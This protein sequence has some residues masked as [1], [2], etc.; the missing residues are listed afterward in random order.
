VSDAGGRAAVEATENTWIPLADGRR[1]AARLW[2]PADA[3]ARPAPAVVEY[4]PYRKRDATR[5]RDE[6]IHAWLAARGYA[7]LRVDMHGSGDSDGV[8]AQEFQAREQDDACEM[9]AWIAAQPWCSGA[10]AMLGKSWGA[11]AAI[12]AAMR[13]PPALKA[14]VAVC[15]AQDRYD[16]SLHFTGGVPLVEQLWWSDAMM[17][18]N[19]RPPDPDIAGPRW[20][21]MWRE[22]LEANGPWIVEWLRHQ[23]RDAFWRHGSHADAPGAIACPILAVGGW[24]DYISRAVPRMLASARAPRWGIV[25]PWGHHYP[26][27]GIPGPAIGFMEECERFLAHALRGDDAAMAGVP[28]LRAWMPEERGLGPDHGVERGRWVAEAA[29]PSPRIA[30][31]AFFPS[32]TGLADAPGPEAVLRHRSSQSIGECA[33]EWLSM[34]LPGEAPR[35]QRADDGRSLCLDTA[36]LGERIEILGAAELELEL[37][38]D[39]PVAMLVARLCDVAPDGASTRVALG[40]LNLCHREGHDRVVPMEPGRRTRV[41]LRL[42]ETAHAFRPGH[43]VRIALSTAYWPVLWPSPEPVALA[44][45]TRGSRLVLP[46]RPVAGAPPDPAFAPP[47]SGPACAVE[48]L[49][50]ATI[51]RHHR[52]DVA[53]GEREYV[54]EGDGGFLGPGRRWRLGETGTEIGHRIVRRFSIRDDDPASARAAIEEEMEIGRG[55]WQARLSTRS[56]MRATRENY[57]LAFAARAEDASGEVF[58]REWRVDVPRDGT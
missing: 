3:R 55:A 2:L 17:L 38:V 46:V 37:E 24:A 10:V 26:Q 41:R 5:P 33:P 52:H 50:P 23:R 53:T 6:P 19:M 20:R 31:R 8:L 29:W 11:F 48:V 27:D 56:E 28:M 12:Q 14:I 34:G 47:S 15:G 9:V 1:L 13:R 42:P 54:V 35:D 49:Q 7:A 32:A 58:A 22:R 18:F 25:G 4:M 36:P 16:E 40:V 44:I 43:R 21:E 30:P 45:A 57:V 39:R 51:R